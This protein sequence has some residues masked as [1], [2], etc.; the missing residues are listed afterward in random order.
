MPEPKT[1]DLFKEGIKPAK[2]EGLPYT[3]KE[4]IAYIEQ[5]YY[6]SPSG[7]IPTQEEI[8]KALDLSI[9][10]VRS[11]WT[12]DEFKSTLVD[13]GLEYIERGNGI[14]SPTQIMFANALLNTNDKSSVRQLLELFNVKST[15]YHAWLREAT[16]Q[17]Y[18]RTRAEQIFEASDYEAYKALV[19]AV[20]S[21]DV[22]AIKFFF[23]L[24]G[25]YNPK[26]T[27]NINIRSVMTEVIRVITDNVKDP[28]VI[29]AIA[30]ELEKISDAP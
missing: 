22:N 9:E 29:E 12:R 17:S 25:I 4:I 14:L 7:K 10:R 2:S 11:A 5:E 30:T 23:E 19:R 16:F 24:R 13:R 8:A 20:S 21:G 1:L 18:L 27:V 3:D 15:Q 28:Q 26:L 6:T